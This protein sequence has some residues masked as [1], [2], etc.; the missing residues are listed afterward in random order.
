ML[1]SLTATFIYNIYS[2]VV[3][4]RVLKSKLPAASS[5]FRPGQVDGICEHFVYSVHKVVCAA[6]YACVPSWIVAALSYI[7]KGTVNWW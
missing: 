4:T 1:C 3:Q 6:K 7:G 5:D 2:V